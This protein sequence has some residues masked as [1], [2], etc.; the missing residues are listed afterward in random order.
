MY[1]MEEEIKISEMLE[2]ENINEEDFIPII[3]DGINKK[4]SASK[5]G[6]GGGGAIGDT[7]PVGSIIPYTGSGTPSNWLKC[8]GAAI[9]RTEYS[10]L[11][12]TIGTLY[13]NGDGSTT[14]NLPDLRDKFVLGSGTNY[15][16]GETGGEK[17]H[18]LTQN[19]IPQ[20][21]VNMSQTNWYD[22]GGL[23]SG[24]AVNRLVVAGGANAGNTSNVIGIVKGGGQAHNNMPPYLTT[25]FIIKAKQSAGLVATI[26]DN[27]T[28][29]ST[30][31]ALSANQGKVLNDKIEEG[32]I[33]S[34]NEIK[35]GTWIDGK[36]IYRKVVNFT[37]SSDTTNWQVID[38][39]SNL[40]NIINISGYLNI[41]SAENMVIPALGGGNN[42]IIT[43]Y[44]N[45]TNGNVHLK[46]TFS[47][48]DGKS[49]NVILEYTKTTD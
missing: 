9:S 6:T 37:L 47:Y 41:R 17:E 10:E 31:D 19:E 45:R 28:S 3:Q 30:T 21:N 49:G 11:F 22:R 29:T 42:E 46:H 23:E 24:G 36:P 18:T 38:T 33:Y 2:A 44:Y 34:T 48:V 27:L 25:T 1:K 16:I 7:L 35:I 39:I 43:S 32:G 15:S 5:V 40:D 8:N 26:V 4:I 20:M 12:Y 13:G 14:F